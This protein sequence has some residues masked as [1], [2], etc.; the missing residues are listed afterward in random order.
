M[1]KK[2]LEQGPDG[3]GDEDEG[4][5]QPTPGKLEMIYLSHVFLDLQ[6]YLTHISRSPNISDTYF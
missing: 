5:I 3:E 1:S 4:G 2:V 6:I